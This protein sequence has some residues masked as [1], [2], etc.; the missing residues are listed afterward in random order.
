MSDLPTP[1]P[2]PLPANWRDNCGGSSCTC[3]A[4][5]QCECSCFD[6][7]WTPFDVYAYRELLNMIYR[8]T[9]SGDSPE[10]S[11][12]IIQNHTLSLIDPEPCIIDPALR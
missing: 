3:G 11:L 4:Y 12:S 1:E 5:D 7:D 10:T 8:Q 6:V 2:Y 9:V